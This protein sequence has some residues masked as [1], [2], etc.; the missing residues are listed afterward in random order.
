MATALVTGATGFF[1]HHIA[2]ALLKEGWTVRAL[3]RD[4]PRRRP[5]GEWNAA[6]ERI[7]G[8]LSAATDLSA[9]A[10]GCDALVHVAGLVKART[11]E[12]YREVNARGTERLVAAA[13]KTAPGA[14]FVL[15]S[16]QAAAGPARN[17]VAVREG[18]PAR[19][20]SWYGISKREGEL[21]VERAWPGPRIALRPGVLYGA[22]DTGLFAYFRMAAS[23]LV[24]VPAATARIQTGAVEESALAVARAASRR[25]LS[26]RTGFLCDP[27]PITIRALAAAIA[28]LPEK[29]ARLVRLPNSVVRAAALLETLRETVTRQ[30]RPFNADKARELLAGDWLCDPTPMRRDLGLPSPPPLLD[31]LQATWDW[32]L[33]AGWIAT[34]GGQNPKRALPL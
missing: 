12:D 16:S 26:G 6:I 4:R 1:G 3:A 10:E 22:G 18:D 7:P 2:A 21:A 11:L 5:P 32:Y 34:S 28:R 14:L 29:P 20:V 27:Q 17:G 13:R 31:G 23:G 25:D 24:P 8:D 9:A 19:P 33:Q 15:I 30:S